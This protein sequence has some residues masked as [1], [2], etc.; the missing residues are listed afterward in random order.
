VRLRVRFAETD[1]M[2]VAHH[3]AFVVWMEAGRVEWLRSRGMSY[4]RMEDEGVSLAVSGLEMSY[5]A[6]ARFDDELEVVTRL[7]LARHRMLRFS[8]RIA[9]VGDGA[10]LATGATV[11]VPT[12]RA[13]RA[14][15]L[16]DRWLDPLLPH[17]G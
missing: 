1:Q 10:L 5:R 13:G 4:R 15:R 14:V 11:H 3:S 16:E 2:G 8:Y 9:R 17:V 7:E 12:N 6:A